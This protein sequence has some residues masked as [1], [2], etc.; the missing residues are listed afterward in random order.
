MTSPGQAPGDDAARLRTSELL[1]LIAND[2]A[3]GSVSLGEIVDRFGVRAFGILLVIATLTAFIPTP[4]GAGSV[5][6][7]LSVL[8]GAQLLFGM[9]RPWLPAWMRRR[10]IARAGVA[11]FLR[12]MGKSLGWLER[13]AMPRLTELFQGPPARISGML[14]VVHSVILALPIP[15]TNF[16]LAF[17]LLLVAIALIED[18]GAILIAS[19]LVMTA[20][21]VAT[22]LLSGELVKLVGGWFGQ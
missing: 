22:V 10:A 2:P 8:V 18:D 3:G 21:A 20:V 1:A 17:V 13:L 5:A 16:P 11:T 14:I 7:A 6:G 4:I 12:R 19:W 15:L 9:R